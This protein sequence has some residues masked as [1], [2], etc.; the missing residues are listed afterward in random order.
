M[1]KYEKIPVDFETIEPTRKF[2][3]GKT[4]VVRIIDEKDLKEPMDLSIP[5]KIK[6]F[7]SLEED[8]PAFLS[9]YDYELNFPL[10]PSDL[11]RQS[12]R[13]VWW[14]ISVTERNILF[15][16]SWQASPGE[17]QHKKNCPYIKSR[18][19]HPLYNSL[20]VRFKEIADEW[21][22]DL[23]KDLRP[24]IV[25]PCSTEKVFWR[26]NKCGH[27]YSSLIYNKTKGRGCPE[28][29]KSLFQKFI[30]NILRNNGIDINTEVAIYKNYKYD[31]FSE[32]DSLL[33]ETDGLHHLQSIE[34]FEKKNSFQERVTWD[35]QKNEYAL[36]KGIPLLRVPYIKNYSYFKSHQEKLK[37]WVLDFVDTRMIPQEI[38]DFYAEKNPQSNYPEIARIMNTWVTE[39][40]VINKELGIADSK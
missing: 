3:E 36:D 35:N 17:R 5:K 34:A 10:K 29:N 40:K 22:W 27:V 14:T 38:I 33:I 39:N 31:I 28:C 9:E 19:V 7:V 20:Q 18:R 6:G 21:C 4:Y 26:C 32:N 15:Y 24:D 25:S 2:L 12:H 37:R 1:S 8:N 11:A 16:I 13:K 30:E 23:N